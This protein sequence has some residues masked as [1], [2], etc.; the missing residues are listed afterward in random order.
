MP[1]GAPYYIDAKQFC[2]MIGVAPSTL[3]RMRVEGRLPVSIKIGRNRRW[4][5]QAITTWLQDIESTSGL[6]TA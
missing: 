3:E 4:S 6:A 5:L 1:D 2:E